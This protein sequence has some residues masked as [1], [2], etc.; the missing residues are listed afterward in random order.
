MSLPMR[1]VEYG[2][3]T[4][5]SKNDLDHRA[6]LRHCLRSSISPWLPNGPIQGH[7]A[8]VR[9]IAHLIVESQK[10]DLNSYRVE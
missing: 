2:H 10:K 5:D 6:T 9:V 7:E 3:G 8:C 4:R 1:E